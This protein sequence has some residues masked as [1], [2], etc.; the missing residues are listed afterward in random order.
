[1][2]VKKGLPHS[3]PAEKQSL[4]S[5]FPGLAIPN[6]PQKP[7]EDSAVVADLMA[8]FEAD[9]PSAGQRKRCPFIRV[10]S[11]KCS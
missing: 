8:Q 9:A 10:L 1:M 2:R 3:A 11:S 5:K 6:E 4:A 7:L